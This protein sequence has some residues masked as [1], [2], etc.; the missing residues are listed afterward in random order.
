MIAHNAMV[1][2]TPGLDIVAGTAPDAL[3]NL[4]TP[5]AVFI[6][7]GISNDGVFEACLGRAQAI[8]PAGANAVTVEGE[9]RL[10]AL[11]AVHGGELC[12]CR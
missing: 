5:D 1:L 7:G 2:G 8:W 10:F 6:G 9:A 3:A 12:G 4:E 11:Q